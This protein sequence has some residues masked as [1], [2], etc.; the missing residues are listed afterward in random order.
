MRD[1]FA[2][3]LENNL[4]KK[5]K[6]LIKL[7][8]VVSLFGSVALADGDMG[9]G[10]LQCPPE[11]CQPPPCTVNCPGFTAQRADDGTEPVSDLIIAGTDMAIDFVGDMLQLY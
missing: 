1:A 5:M 9:A 11:G 6:T 7:T 8:L 10:N 4:E 2:Y 3:Q